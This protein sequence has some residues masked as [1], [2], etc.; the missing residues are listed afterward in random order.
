M[1]LGID[2]T[3]CVSTILWK[4]FIGLKR[5][6]KVRVS[7]DVNKYQRRPRVHLHIQLIWRLSN[8]QIYLAIFRFFSLEWYYSQFKIKVSHT[9]LDLI[10][11]HIARHSSYSAR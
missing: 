8:H 2:F 5:F 9:L 1:V 4:I 11:E 6:K 7:Q 3:F 10:I